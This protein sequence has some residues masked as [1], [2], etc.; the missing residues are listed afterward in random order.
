M[1]AIKAKYYFCFIIILIIFSCQHE[2]NVKLISKKIFKKVTFI[3]KGKI[4]LDESQYKIGELSPYGFVDHSQNLYF[5]DKKN[6][7]FLKFSKSGTLKFIIGK[8]GKGP[9][10]YIEPHDI[11]VDN[12]GFIY[13]FD[14]SKFATIIYDSD[15]SFWKEIKYDKGIP[16]PGTFLANENVKIVSFLEYGDNNPFKKINF[17]HFLDSNFTIYKSVSINYP[18]IYSKYN[19]VN[20]RD[21]YWCFDDRYFYVLFAAE[22]YI[23][24]FNQNGKFIQRF[25]I[26]P[27]NFQIVNKNVLNLPLSEKIKQLSQFSIN[28]RL[29]L[30][31]KDFLLQI[32]SKTLLPKDLSRIPLFELNKF[33]KFYYWIHTTKGESIS[34]SNNLLSGTPLFCTPEGFFYLLSNNEPSK[35]EI[36]IYEIK[37]E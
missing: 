9:G 31:R 6:T 5:L 12:K 17:F 27:S 11:F 20:Y 4:L 34:L 33:R 36:T 10:E 26:V 13:I 1:R 2:K 24:K 32:Y 15:G 18:S 3:K 16:Y 28:N 29:F 7:V 23:Y 30:F 25:G 35:R 19:L 22:P 37:I 14:I 8:K 21:I